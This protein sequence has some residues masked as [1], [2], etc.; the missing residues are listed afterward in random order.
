MGEIETKKYVVAP[1]GDVIIHLCNFDPPFAVLPEDE[2]LY[3]PRKI[4][5]LFVSTS[6]FGSTGGLFGSKPPSDSTSAFGSG[7]GLFGSKPTSGFT[8]LFGSAAPSGSK[9]TSGF[10]SLF[11]SAAPS[12][13]KPTFS[14]TGP[15]DSTAPPDSTTPSSSTGAASSADNLKQQPQP[16]SDDVEHEPT[17]VAPQ[18][19]SEKAV[20]PE[21]QTE[22]SVSSPEIHLQVSSAHLKLASRYFQKAFDGKF[23]ESQPDSDGLL[24]V[25]ASGWDMEALLIVLWVIHG[26]NRGIPKTIDLELLAKIAVIV[27]Y[28]DCHEMFDA[29]AELWLQRLKGRFILLHKLDR[30][31]VLLLFVSW[32]FGWTNEFKLATRIVLHQ[33]KGPL[34][35]L[36]LPIP[37]AITSKFTPITI[38]LEAANG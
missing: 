8:G 38:I 31:L 29:F 22:P 12:G 33:S 32:M 36:D 25:D 10:T 27:D 20:K 37:E 35:T 17:R 24:H 9:P 3:V 1:N 26:K 21:E 13:S 4:K 30:E 16:H 7:G 34:R 5:P 23:K 18:V 6:A 15:L 11:S 28:Y 14:F 2:E 19:P